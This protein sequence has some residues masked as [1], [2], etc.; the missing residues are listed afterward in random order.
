MHSV[1]V[2]PE[3]VFQALAD[4]TRVRVVRLLA[5][6]GEESCLCE[7][8]DSLLEPQY[9]LSRHVKIL[10]QAGL[11]S[12]E[13]SGRWVYHRLVTDVPCLLHLYEMVRALPDREREFAQDLK[14]F[15]ARMCLREGGRCRL[16]IQTPAFAVAQA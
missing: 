3:D 9:K 14:R 6:T 1:A 10:R 11:L 16:G 2:K 8:V 15:K 5:S 4:P 13:K 12:V 7:L